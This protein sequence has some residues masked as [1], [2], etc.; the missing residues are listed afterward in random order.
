[1]GDGIA[2]TSFRL[3]CY[4]AAQL[5]IGVFGDRYFKRPVTAASPGTG[6]AAH[7]VLLARSLFGLSQSRQAETQHRQHYKQAFAHSFL[8]NM[9]CNFQ[10][11]FDLYECP[12]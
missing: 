11:E 6:P 12:T 10:G 7:Q 5:A 8:L 3:R 9:K 4:A 2:F 1:E